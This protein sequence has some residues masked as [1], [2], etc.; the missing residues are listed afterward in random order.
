MRF[1]DFASWSV[2]SLLTLAGLAQTEDWDYRNT[3]SDRP[4][5]ILRNYILYTFRRAFQQKEVAVV[6][7]DADRVACFNTGLLTPHFERIFGYFVVQTRAEYPQPWF[8]EG[9]IEKA[10]TVS[11][12]SRSYRSERRTSTRRLTSSTTLGSTFEFS[13]S[14]SSTIDWNVF[15]R[16]CRQTSANGLPTFA[17]P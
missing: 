6:E 12:G 1:H 2:A 16:S 7:T 14:T 13:T 15:P 4:L 11:C 9:S 17:K 10:T 8:L 3:T 5:P